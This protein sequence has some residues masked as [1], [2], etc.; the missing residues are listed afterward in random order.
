[1]FNN[2]NVSK[3]SK[4]AN[5]CHTT[6]ENPIGLLLLAEV[7]LGKM[8]PLKKAKYMDKPPKGSN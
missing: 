1:V 8:Y 7:A 2:T 4:S 6:N 3:V 5:Y